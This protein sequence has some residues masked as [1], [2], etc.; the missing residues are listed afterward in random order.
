MRKALTMQFT[1]GL[2]I[3]YGISIAGYWAYGS[4]VS[5]YLPYQL[6]GPKWANI[7]INLTA[8]LQSI[9]SQH[10]SSRTSIVLKFILFA[11]IAN[12]SGSLSAIADVLRTN[13][14][15]SWHQIPKARWR[16]VLQNQLPT[17][18]PFASI[19]LWAKHICDCSVSVH[20]GFC[21]PLWVFYAF[22]AYFRV[23]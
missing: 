13:S 8:F 6:S 20:G 10:V 17:A 18:I 15:G 14:W 9:V 4:A 12:A 5:E 23:P 21:E 7:L 11:I 1:I 22:P 2:V 3:Y 19:T 16:D